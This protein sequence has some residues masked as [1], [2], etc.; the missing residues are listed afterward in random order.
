M[1]WMELWVPD[2]EC[3]HCECSEHQC[4]EFKIDSGDSSGIKTKG[5]WA[6]CSECCEQ[7][8][9]DAKVE[10]EMRFD[11]SYEKLEEK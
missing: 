7:F 4:A 6:V 9:F 5:A 3:P 2:V 1:S 11:Q 10:F 8:Y